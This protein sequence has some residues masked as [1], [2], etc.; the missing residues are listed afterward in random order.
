M[1]LVAAAADTS[2]EQPLLAH[3]PQSEPEHGHEGEPEAQPL[4]HALAS[5]AAEGPAEEDGSDTTCALLEV[6]W[7]G[8]RE[9]FVGS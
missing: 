7:P 3:H 4:L 9:G 5:A 2:L 6:H 8:K 1:D